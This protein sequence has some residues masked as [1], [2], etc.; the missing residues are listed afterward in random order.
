MRRLTTLSEKKKVTA[1]VTESGVPSLNRYRPKI[2]VTREELKAAT[3]EDVGNA[4]EFSSSV[5]YFL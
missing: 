2:V 1:V 3:E 4:G 5:Q